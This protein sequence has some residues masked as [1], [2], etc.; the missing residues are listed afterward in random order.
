MHKDHRT[1]IDTR[2]AFLNGLMQEEI[3]SADTSADVLVVGGRLSESTT[4]AAVTENS[5]STTAAPAK[6]RYWLPAPVRCLALHI[7]RYLTEQL[8]HD[9]YV[10][11]E[12]S[13]ATII[14]R[15]VSENRETRGQ[16]RQ[17]SARLDNLSRRSAATE[18]QVPHLPEG[19]P[20]KP[21]SVQWPFHSSTPQATANYAVAGP[22]R[23]ALDEIVLCVE[24]LRREVSDLDDFSASETEAPLATERRN[25]IVTLSKHVERLAVQVTILSQSAGSAAGSEFEN[26]GA[27]EREARPQLR[28]REHGTDE[29]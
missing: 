16:I 20:R 21:F 6:H 3:G 5:S 26:N 29:R 2:L 8:R 28:P 4:V 1:S 19:A 17:L 15:F 13:T 24:T 23:S 14:D 10:Q 18:I 7:R 25:K 11:V 22:L 27:R 9:L 12:H